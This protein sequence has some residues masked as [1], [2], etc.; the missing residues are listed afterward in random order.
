MSEEWNVSV[1]L[2]HFLAATTRR[3]ELLLEHGAID[4]SNPRRESVEWGAVWLIQVGAVA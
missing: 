2:H 4:G 3:E 1:A